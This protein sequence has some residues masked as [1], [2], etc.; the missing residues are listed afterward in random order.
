MPIMNILEDDDFGKDIPTA[1]E[2]KI[3]GLGSSKPCHTS[4]VPQLRTEKV[5]TSSP[6]SDDPQ[7]PNS[8]CSSPTPTSPTPTMPQSR[9]STASLVEDGGPTCGVCSS[10]VSLDY[11]EETGSREATPTL[12]TC[13]P[14]TISQCQLMAKPSNDEDDDDE[15]EEEKEEALSSDDDEETQPPPKKQKTKS[16]KSLVEK[17]VTSGK[18][19]GKP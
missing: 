9:Q 10:S 14:T 18:K 15:N 5:P 16:S 19:S 3:L 2:L 6:S 1:E 4:D 11:E 8:K 13:T 17:L 7:L 12:Q